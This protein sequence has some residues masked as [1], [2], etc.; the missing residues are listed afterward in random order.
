M[1]HSKITI[2]N[3]HE[4]K[5]RLDTHPQ[6][7][8]I[9]VRELHE[10][11]MLHIPGALHIPKDELVHRITAQVPELDKAIYLY[12]KAGVRSLYAANC[13]IEMGYNTIYSL[14]GGI[15]EWANSGYYIV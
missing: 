11:Q 3:V 13:L 1:S 15:T 5:T 7:C 12:C 14:D 9:D 8:L 2:I 10:W 6:L 4:L